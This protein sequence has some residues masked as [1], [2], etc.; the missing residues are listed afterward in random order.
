MRHV[1]LLSCLLVLLPAAASARKKAPPPPPPT[2]AAGQLDSLT[3]RVAGDGQR[4]TSA[5][6]DEEPVL[7]PGE[8]IVIADVVGPAVI[9]RLWIAVEGSNSFWRDL[10]IRITYAGA[11]GPSVLAPLGDFFGVGPG[12]RQNI[13]SAPLVVRSGGRS[14]TSYWKMPVPTG[15][16]VELVNSGVHPT[17]QLLWEVDWRTVDALPPGTLLFHASWVQASPPEAGKPVSIL[18]ASG[19]GQFVGL[20]LAVQNGAPGNWGNGRILFEVDGKDDAGPGALPL[21]NYFGGIFGVDDRDGQ[22][23]GATL[24]EG[25]REKARTSLYRFHLSDPVGF[26]KSLQIE[27]EHGRKNQRSDRLA[28]VAYWY[29]AAAGVPFAKMPGARDRAWPAPSDS[30]LKLWARADEL[31]DQVIDAYRRDDYDAA[32]TLLEE[33]LS[34]EPGLVYANYNLACLYALKGDEAKALHLLEQ[35][36]ELGFTETS[37]ARQDPDLVSL[38]DHERFK[39][40]VGI[41]E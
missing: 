13:D 8:A 12:A 24:S 2:P 23:M 11:A 35:A 7:G 15:A 31:D 6:L 5:D 22:T 4:S 40:L 26:D 3:T 17:R 21:L 37:F 38:H 34:L 19:A 9:D 27:V 33:L 20:S 28:A 1:T 41:A 29:Q 39:K 14:M 16:T 10:E 36:I 30:E 25:T 18:R 32:L